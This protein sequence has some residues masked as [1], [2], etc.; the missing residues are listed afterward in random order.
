MEDF[1]NLEW[2]APA[3]DYTTEMKKI[4]KSLRKRNFLIVC[5]CLVLVA[6]IAFGTIQYGIPAL[7]KQY[8]DPNTS[9]YAENVPDLQLTMEAY[10]ELFFPQYDLFTFEITDSGFATYDITA[11]FSKWTSNN[12]ISNSI[13]SPRTAVLSKNELDFPAGFWEFT[14]DAPF[15]TVPIFEEHWTN[16]ALQSLKKYPEYINVLAAV[17]FP[18]DITVQNSFEFSSNFGKDSE[19][20]SV[21]FVVRSGDSYETSYPA[22]GYSVRMLSS[23]HTEHFGRES[24]YPYLMNA[25]ASSYMET[26]FKSMLRFL[27]DQ[28]AQGTGIL[29]PDCEN[30]SYYAD[31]LD[32]VE[33]N[34]VNVYGAYVI[35]SP[36]ALLDLYESGKISGI[37]LCDA[38]IN[39]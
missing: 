30:E 15:N 18:E 35:S 32:Y 16:A 13:E 19:Y 28:Q 7:E 12:T 31:V 34:G 24:E 5:T 14:L 38:W 33:E 27:R 10:T 37:G 39:Y 21:W 11:T 8:W 9:T 6:V 1:E 22:C 20:Q 17:T 29:P 36:K 26:H 4:R 3:F 23:I 25:P 2:E